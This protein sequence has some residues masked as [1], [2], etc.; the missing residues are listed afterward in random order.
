MN[1]GG[2]E[3]LF[4]SLPTVLGGLALLLVVTNGALVALNRATQTRVA[5]RAQYV[6]QTVQLDRI[7]QTIVRAAA[8]AAINSKDARLGQVLNANGI[9]YQ[10]T[11][12]DAPSGT[13][14]PTTNP[15]GTA[16]VAR[17]S[18]SGASPQVSKGGR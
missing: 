12:P 2:L 5:A 8:T 14:T 9:T 11:P 10:S 17:G 1:R 18:G 6:N 3:Q 4:S 16:A 13:A 15:T 7:Q